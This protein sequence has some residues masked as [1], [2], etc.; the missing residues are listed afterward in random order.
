MALQHQPPDL[1]T[2]LQRLLAEL[3]HL[4][5]SYSATRS[6]EDLPELWAQL[7]H[8]QPHLEQRWPAQRLEPWTHPEVDHSRSA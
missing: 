5:G 2:T 7:D 6:R 8:I 3:R 4:E 1:D